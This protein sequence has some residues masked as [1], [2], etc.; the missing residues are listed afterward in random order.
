MQEIRGAVQGID[1]PDRLSV[2]MLLEVTFLGDDAV[3]GEVMADGAADFFLAVGVHT[4]KEVKLCLF[5][6][7]ERV[8]AQTFPADDLAGV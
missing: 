6:H 7:F 4:A 1:V 8:N 5:V 3:I 2:G